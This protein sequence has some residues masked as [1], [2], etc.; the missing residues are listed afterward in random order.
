MNLLDNRCKPP[1]LPSFRI[2]QSHQ[3]LNGRELQLGVMRERARFGLQKRR[4]SQR[5]VV[6]LYF[7][8]SHAVQ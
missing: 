1:D 2:P 3:E 4:E 7:P 6:F 5:P 8:G